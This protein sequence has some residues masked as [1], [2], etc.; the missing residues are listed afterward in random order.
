MS[1][2]SDAHTSGPSSPGQ[3]FGHTIDMGYGEEDVERMAEGAYYDHRDFRADVSRAA[4]A[5]VKEWVRAFLDNY[6]THSG[7]MGWMPDFV[8]PYS[9]YGSGDFEAE[10]EGGF[11]T[12][13]AIDDA[14]RREFRGKRTAVWVKDH[15]KSK[16]EHAEHDAP[17]AVWMLGGLQWAFSEL[18]H[19]EHW[20]ASTL[21]FNSRHGCASCKE[22]NTQRCAHRP[23]PPVRP[24]P[25]AKSIIANINQHHDTSR[26]IRRQTTIIGLCGYVRSGKRRRRVSASP[27]GCSCTERSRTR[28]GILSVT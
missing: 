4:E 11:G 1:A 3:A 12:R 16:F 7:D 23:Q 8:W 17:S 5:Y 9:G 20:R 13:I 19:L 18:R 24:P 28:L 27:R 10:L 22:D 25:R 14:F 2:A 6:P 15:N 21:W 26:H